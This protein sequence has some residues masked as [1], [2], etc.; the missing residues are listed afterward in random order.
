MS[1]LVSI[2]DFATSFHDLARDHAE[3]SR[4]TFGDDES[5]GPM[6]AL[7]HLEK[8]AVEAQQAVGTHAI[9]EELADCLLLLLDASR[10]SGVKPLQLVKAAQEKMEKNKAR[11]WLQ[12]IADE[13]VE[14][15]R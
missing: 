14:H 13:P 7:K 12:P 10:R 8:E 2:L 9:N 6:G 3:W 15:V 4:E 1:F 5:R 11:T